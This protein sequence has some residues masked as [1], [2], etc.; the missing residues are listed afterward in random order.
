[1]LWT[2]GIYGGKEKCKKDFDGKTEGETTWGIYAY[3]GE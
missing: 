3:M 2:G 1:M